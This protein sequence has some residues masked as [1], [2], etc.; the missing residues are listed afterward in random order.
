M[1]FL[2][3]LEAAFVTAYKKTPKTK[4]KEEKIERVA[5]NVLSNEA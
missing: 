5:V 4:S 2:Q 1:N 3:V